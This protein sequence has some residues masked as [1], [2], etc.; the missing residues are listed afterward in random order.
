[1]AVTE[2]GLIIVQ[3]MASFTVYFF[4]I[5]TISEFSLLSAKYSGG[6]AWSFQY[7]NSFCIRLNQKVFFVGSIFL[8]KTYIWLAVS[9]KSEP[10]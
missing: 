6:H 10:S 9:D 8:S 5:K 2:I 1:M 7:P 4:K 3:K